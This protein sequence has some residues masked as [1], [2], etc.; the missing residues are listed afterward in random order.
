[1]SS[2]GKGCDKGIHFFTFMPCKPNKSSLFRASDVVLVPRKLS[3]KKSTNTTIVEKDANKDK[4]KAPFAT[5]VG[6]G[7]KVVEEV[8]SNSNEDSNDEFT[9]SDK[10]SKGKHDY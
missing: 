6:K 2:I 8:G 7:K 9:N 3:T 10:A 1:M 4:A 5:N